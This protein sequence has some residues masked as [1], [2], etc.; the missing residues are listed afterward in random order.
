LSKT[1]EEEKK[2]LRSICD[3]LIEQK[4]KEKYVQY[5]NALTKRVF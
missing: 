3:I 1:P 2:N 4:A 5:Q